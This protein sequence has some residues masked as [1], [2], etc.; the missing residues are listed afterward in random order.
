MAQSLGISRGRL[1]AA[2][3][4]GYVIRLRSDLYCTAISTASAPKSAG[5]RAKEALLPLGDMPAVV[6]GRLA[7]DLHDLP[8]I[9]PP[10]WLQEHCAS[11][12]LVLEQD[13]ARL[14]R[15][16]VAAIVR[17]ITAFPEDVT[18]VDGIPVTSLLHTAIDMVRLGLRSP[19]RHRAQALAL[20]EA[21]VPLDAATARLG[22]R[23]AEEAAALILRMRDRFRHHP[24]IRAVDHAC[25]YVDP[26]AETPFESWSRGY[27]ALYGIPRPLLQQSVVG[28]DGN[29][30]RVDFCWPELRI[31]G[32]AD[33]LEKY[34]STPE[35]FRKAKAKELARQRALEAAGWTVIR[36][37]WDQFAA[38]P[39]AVMRTLREA[40]QQALAA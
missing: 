17:P 8:F 40:I 14:G 2:L 1:R 23:S 39:A 18:E 37:T 22:A 6:T 25:E 29:T 30:Y 12:I 11:E 7:G 19:Y 24:G 3:A 13:S 38:N 26:L 32:E 20:P 21:L 28:A 5:L 15:R 33:G 10:G 31:I 9:A 16:P 36:W 35:E 34:G 4:R 27:M